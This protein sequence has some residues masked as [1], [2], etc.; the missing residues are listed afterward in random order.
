MHVEE[1]ISEER[2]KERLLVEGR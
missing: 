1:A 2:L